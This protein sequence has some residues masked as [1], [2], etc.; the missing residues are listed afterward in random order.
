MKVFR[1]LE[2]YRKN[3][4]SIPVVTIGTFD[5]VHIG[6]Q[7]IL[8]R[9]NAVARQK[10]GESVLL[11]FWPH[12]RVIIQPEDNKLRLL[13]TLEEKI[14]LLEKYGLQNLIVI[15][16]TKEFSQLK[17]RDFIRK[18]LI[19]KIGVKVLVIGYDHRFGR[20][21]E[22]SMDDLEEFA[23]IFGYEL[24]EIT[25]EE[26]D[27]VAVSST[28][29]R[30]ALAEGEVDK[31]TEYL[32]HRYS[33]TGKVIKGDQLGRKLGY[34]TANIAI[35]EKLKLIPADGVYLV[36]V[37]IENTWIKGMLNIGHRPTIVQHGDKRIEVHI[38]D[39][40]ENL[41]GKNLTI[42]F[43]QWMRADMH[44]KSTE[45]LIEQLKQDEEKAKQLMK[46]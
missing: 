32:G 3:K 18:F 21:R 5:G 41:Y 33:I 13:N 19:E 22:G 26:I 42:E 10:N 16:F 38:F 30:D 27:H 11:T 34:P 29:I 39:F 9:V 12:P 17:A 6:H 4:P 20:N 8:D 25:A 28:K 37:Q 43:L 35:K 15:P 44:F 2:E 36:N 24:E 45:A 40:N 46:L 1:S 23:P 7:K 14:L 31:A